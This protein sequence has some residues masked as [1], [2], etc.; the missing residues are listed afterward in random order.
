M[1]SQ[2]PS[3]HLEVNTVSDGIG[4]VSSRVVAASSGTAVLLG[5]R[6]EKF[7]H[8]RTVRELSY[9]SEQFNRGLAFARTQLWPADEDDEDPQC[10]PDAPKLGTRACRHLLRFWGVNKHRDGTAATPLATSLP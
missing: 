8:T 7:M 4:T 6:R 1:R 10:S 9:V 3:L 5:E 2:G